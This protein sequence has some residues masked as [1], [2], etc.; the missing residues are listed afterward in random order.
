M[1][2]IPPRVIPK[3][4]AMHAVSGIDVLIYDETMRPLLS[5]N[6]RTSSVRASLNGSLRKANMK[7]RQKSPVPK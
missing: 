3:Q 5:E 2:D 1:R 4:F 6:E 7:K